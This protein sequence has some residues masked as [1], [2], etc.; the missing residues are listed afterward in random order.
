MNKKYVNTHMCL[1]ICH[2]KTVGINL[3]SS[4]SALRVQSFHQMLEPGQPQEH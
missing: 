2:L 4:S 3:L 1:L